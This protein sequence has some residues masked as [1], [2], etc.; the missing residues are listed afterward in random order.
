MHAESQASTAL[1]IF[2]R[3]SRRLAA[4]GLPLLALGAFAATEDAEPAKKLPPQPWHMADIWWK[5]E[6]P[7]PHFEALDIDV[8]IDRDVPAD[9]NLYVS[10]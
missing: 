4:A 8:T 9:V 3:T 1:S 6:E 7:T 5:F 2:L 10:P